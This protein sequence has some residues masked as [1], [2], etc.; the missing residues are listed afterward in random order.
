[1][2]LT[3]PQFFLGLGMGMVMSSMTPTLAALIDLR[4]TSADY[5]NAFA[6]YET[7]L[8]IPLTIGMS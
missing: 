1:V 2:V 3:V 8:C 4:Y 6:L 7:A 5:G